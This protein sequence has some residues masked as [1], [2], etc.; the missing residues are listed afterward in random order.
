ME[1]FPV[2]VNSIRIGLSFKK[3][4][5]ALAWWHEYG[6]EKEA[7]FHSHSNKS[8]SH[9]WEIGKEVE[10]IPESFTSL[11]YEYA[12]SQSAKEMLNIG[13]RL[14]SCLATRNK[15]QLPAFLLGSFLRK[16]EL[17]IPLEEVS[18]YTDQ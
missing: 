2:Y 16:A 1:D 7:E 8:A 10:K 5:R 11:V 14:R 13:R 15:G 6:F 12:G 3:Q 9:L 4:L 18:S 17:S